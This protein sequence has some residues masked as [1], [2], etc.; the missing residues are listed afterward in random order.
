MSTKRG[1]A[2]ARAVRLVAPS[3]ARAQDLTRLGCDNFDTASGWIMLDGN[4]EVIVTQQREGEAAVGSV[5]LSRR[6][7]N[8]LV[9]WYQRPQRLRRMERREP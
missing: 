2:T 1:A 6:E 9:A 5:R 7:F 4:D 8:R 3:R